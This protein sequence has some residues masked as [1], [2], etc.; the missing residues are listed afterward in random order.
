MNLQPVGVPG[1]LYIAGAG[2]ARGY[3]NR[4]E[5]TASR[6]IT[7]P[8]VEGQRL[9]RTGDIVKRMPNGELEYVGRKDAQVKIRGYRIEL[10]EIRSALQ[11][12]PPIKEAAVITRND[13][14][15]QQSIYGYA[16]T[17][18]S[19][20]EAE[21]R[22]SLRTLLP[23]YMIPARI[24]Q[25]DE[26]PLTAN[27]KLDENAL[28]EPAANQGAGE[29]I[30]PRNDIEQMMAEIWEELLGME[31]LGVNAHFFHL[32]GDSIKAL[33]VCAR[34]K[35]RGYETTVRELFKH[36]TLGELSKRV[37]KLRREIDQAPVNGE[38]PLT[39]VQHWFFSQSL[40]HDHF[41]QSVM[42]HSSARF[43]ETALQ[44]RSPISW[45]IMTHCGWYADIK[46]EF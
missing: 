18:Q 11:E 2:V 31:G 34:L 36:Q 29:D 24:I 26:L 32:G 8:Y 1:E 43:D 14:D 38:V 10:G 20:N 19:L 37:T 30:S 9:Y 28:P 13:K 12:L 16:V 45:S 22:T 35:Q 40:S 23:E 21:I 27:G 25:V 44:K 4:E 15:G 6:F 42:L 41:H 5:L 3:I 33:Q 7:N 17:A 46:T 39:P